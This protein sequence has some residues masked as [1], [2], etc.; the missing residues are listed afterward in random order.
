MFFGFD[1]TWRWNWRDDQTYYNQ[2]WIQT[3]RY[4]ARSRLGKVELRL[5]RQTPYRRGEP[6]KVMVR[7]PD[8]EKP[9]S[10][11]TKVKVNVERRIPGKESERETRTLELSRME[12]SRG[13]YDTTMTQTPEGEYRFSLIEPTA[14]PRPQVEC[15][16]LAPPGE[17]EMLRMNQA[18]M[19][20]AATATQG[21]FYTLAT[22]DRL[23]NDLPTGNRVTVNSH[24]P[25]WLVWNSSALFL[26]ALGLLTTEWLFRKQKN[27]L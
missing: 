13:T 10:D 5:D 26:L 8:D 21:K 24:G 22:A 18:Q 14:K 17:L 4:L 25:P 12:S 27:L 15:K 1:E 19:E 23:L 20:E 9:P 7:F 11:Q 6:I 2:F 3:V 16:V